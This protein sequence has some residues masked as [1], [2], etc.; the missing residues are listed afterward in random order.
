MKLA[1]ILHYLGISMLVFIVFASGFYFG[2]KNS[3]SK[4]ILIT[5][6][7]TDRGKSSEPLKVKEVEGV[8]WIQPG[9]EPVCP[10]NAPVK[11]KF[12]TDGLNQYYLPEHKN[13]NKIR[14]S[15][16]F[17]TEEFARDKAGFIKKF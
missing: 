9:K 13:Y 16:C 17:A 6:T 5:T 3:E 8:F 11:G 12:G 4:N 1:A 10:E 7:N 14:T 15:I 2:Y